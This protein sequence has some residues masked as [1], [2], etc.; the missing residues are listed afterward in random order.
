M[1]M[2]LLNCVGFGIFYVA[3]TVAQQS[4]PDKLVIDI[5]DAKKGRPNQPPNMVSLD[6]LHNG[7]GR[8][9]PGDWPDDTEIEVSFRRFIK[10]CKAMLDDLHDGT[11]IKIKLLNG[12]HVS[13]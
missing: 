8:Y 11:L 5:L 9:L 4:G 2:Y 7:Y 6:H 3:R 1:R 10:P 13:E 12:T